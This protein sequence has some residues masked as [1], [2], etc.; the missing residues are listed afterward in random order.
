MKKIIFL[1]HSTGL[2]IWY[3]STNKYLRKLFEKSDVKTWFNEYNKKNSTNYVIKQKWFPGDAY[4]G[5]NMPYDYY[6]IWVKHAGETP[7]KGQPTLE[8]LTKEYDI[9]IFKHCYPVSNISPDTGEP[10]INSKKR[11]LENY[12]P[13]YN[14]LKK[15]M[16][17]FPDNKFIVWSPAVQVKSRLKEDEAK[18]TLEFHDWMINEWDEK[19]D[20]IYIW[21]FYNYETEG[22][23]YFPDKY[24]SGPTDSH[25]NKQFS[26]RIA[27]LFAEFIIDVDKGKIK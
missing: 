27:P 21:D 9:I 19:G 5:S 13:Q 16:H 2:A 17:E 14:A 22:G 11:T 25:P 15:K 12:K 10:D 6:N 24:A 20:N 7:Y 18:R 26:G 23:L 3:G 4:N 8:T 1:H